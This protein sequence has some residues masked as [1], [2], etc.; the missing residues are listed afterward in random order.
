[1]PR[2]RVMTE[3]ELRRRMFKTADQLF[4]DAG[5]AQL[6]FEHINFERIAGLSDVGRSAAYRVFPN[7]DAF[8][9]EW[10]EHVAGPIGQEAAAFD[11]ETQILAETIVVERAEELKTA[12]GRRALL[13]EAVRQAAHRNF[14]S[15]TSKN[16][17]RSYQ[18]LS[19][20]VRN[21]ED[22][23]LRAKVLAQLQESDR[24]FSDNMSK[25]Y[26]L[27]IGVLGLR[28]RA[29]F[30][31][32]AVFEVLAKL[33]GAVV[34]GLALHDFVDPDFKSLSFDIDGSEWSIASIGFMAV[35][36]AVAEPDP[37]FVYDPDWLE[38]ATPQLLELHGG[39]SGD[40]DA[41]GGTAT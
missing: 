23:G 24:F 7:K 20:T 22:E 12:H 31:E 1:M 30:T 5:G 25:F 39:A 10:L 3:E 15:L 8:L 27:M 9:E 41:A 17:W 35:V 11:E 33:G 19:L 18:V 36:D 32:K 37:D 38:K 34:E 40:D 29:P 2:P 13:L 16:T 21:I 6:S 28:P 4:E 14:L 26:A